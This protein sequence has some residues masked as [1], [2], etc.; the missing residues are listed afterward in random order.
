MVVLVI[1]S[2]CR[3]LSMPQS[4]GECAPT[5]QN[6]SGRS[7][8]GRSAFGMASVQEGDHSHRP[9]LRP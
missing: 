2:Y 8:S 4:L 9:R 7:E 6:H 5:Y 3:Q 1:P